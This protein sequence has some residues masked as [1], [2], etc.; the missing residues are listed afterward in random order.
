MISLSKDLNMATT[1]KKAVRKPASSK[2]LKKQNI[3]IVY[4]TKIQAKNTL[5]PEKLKKV[6]EILAKID[7]IDF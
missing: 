5:F 3:V 2:R 6:N 1:K 7:K 4:E